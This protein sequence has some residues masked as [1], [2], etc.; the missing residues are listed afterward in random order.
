VSIIG[1]HLLS[2]LLIC[3]LKTPLSFTL[4]LTSSNSKVVKK[5]TDKVLERGVPRFL[6]IWPVQSSSTRSIFLMGTGQTPI[7]TQP[8]L[9]QELRITEQ[10]IQNTE[11]LL[12]NNIKK[13]DSRNGRIKFDSQAVFYVNIQRVRLR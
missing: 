1:D 9:Y 11:R 13:P 7:F 12:M 3:G 6:D 10:I 4:G 2:V 8:F 5:M